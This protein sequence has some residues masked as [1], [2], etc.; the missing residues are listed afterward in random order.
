MSQ[1]KEYHRKSIRLKDYEYS[2][3]GAYFIAIC[4]YKRD[5][6]I[7]MPNHTH[8]MIIVVGQPKTI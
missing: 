5:E 3:P 2:Q 6:F 4:T 8:G 7:V 1:T